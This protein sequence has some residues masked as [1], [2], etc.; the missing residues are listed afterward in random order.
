MGKRRREVQSE[1]MWWQ[2]QSSKIRPRRPHTVGSEEEG[3]SQE[4]R[5]AGSPEKLEKAR[6]GL[7]CWSLRKACS[8]TIILI[9]AQ[10]DF[11]PHPLPQTVQWQSPAVSSR[12]VCGDRKQVQCDSCA[13]WHF[14]LPQTY[15][16]FFFK[17]ALTAYGCSQA[18]D[19]IWVVSEIYATAVATLSL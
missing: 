12:W 6:Q 13:L 11:W 17:A 5:D 15:G 8:S 4:P 16:N 2:K 1:E 3:G 18:R 19:W 7:L 9:L 10:V 14:H